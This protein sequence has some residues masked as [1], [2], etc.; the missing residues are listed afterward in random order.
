MS[1]IQPVS[2][3]NNV[4][5]LGNDRRPKQDPVISEHESNNSE[6]KGAEQNSIGETGKGNI[7]DIKI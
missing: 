4:N 7:I 5:N 3:I 1:E 6:D 2:P